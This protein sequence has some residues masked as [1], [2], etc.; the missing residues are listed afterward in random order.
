MDGQN[1]AEIGTTTGLSYTDIVSESATYYYE[2]LVTDGT[3]ESKANPTSSASYSV[4]LKGQYTSPAQLVS[5]IV[6]TE[7]AIRH[8]TVNWIT[9]RASDTKI[10]YG[11][12]SGQYFDEELY[13]SVQTT[14]HKIRLNS[15]QA[16][17]IYYF[18]AKWTDEDGNTGMSQEISFRTDPM[19]EVIT[20]KVERV[21]L[22]FATISFEVKGASKASVYYGRVTHTRG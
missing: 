2:V 4:N 13:N 16:D 5:G 8:A 3:D 7:V 10:M 17:T 14:D 11:T 9:D 18:K 20:S 6:L 22:D 1:W 15:L 19:P 21:G 12:T